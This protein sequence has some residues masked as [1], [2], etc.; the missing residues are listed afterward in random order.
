[1]EEL[2]LASR[3]QAGHGAVV[4]RST[5]WCGG[6]GRRPQVLL[7]EE[8]LDAFGVPDEGAQFHVA[9]RA[10]RRENAEVSPVAMPHPIRAVGKNSA[11]MISLALLF[12]IRT[13]PARREGLGRNERRGRI[14][15]PRSEAAGEGR[16]SARTA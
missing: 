13:E 16:S 9:T 7:A 14:L 10:H 11:A 8:A 6:Y 2:L 15:Q 3:R 1:V 12:E 4:G 5:R